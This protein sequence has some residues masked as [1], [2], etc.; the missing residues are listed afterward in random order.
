M[1]LLEDLEGTERRASPRK[2]SEEKGQC[3]KVKLSCLKMKENKATGHKSTF[4]AT[5][6][7][8]LGP[9]WPFWVRPKNAY[10]LRI[11]FQKLILSL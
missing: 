5:L 1:C 10:F 4:F 9:F 6:Y 7:C 3:Q 2:K 8:V 11:R